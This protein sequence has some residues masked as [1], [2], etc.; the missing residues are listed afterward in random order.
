MSVIDPLTRPCS[1]RNESWAC[2]ITS[3]SALPIPTTSKR[4]GADTADHAIC[5]ARGGDRPANARI[6]PPRPPGGGGYH[7]L[8]DRDRDPD[9]RPVPPAPHRDPSALRRRAGPGPQRGGVRR[10]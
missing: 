5:L 9:A 4:A 2:A 1:S 3:T 10:V 6:C 7:P 8:G